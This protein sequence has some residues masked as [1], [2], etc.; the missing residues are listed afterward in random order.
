[1][2][3]KYGDEQSMEILA[4]RIDEILIR[5]A[6]VLL[7]YA[8]ATYELNDQISD[9]DLDISINTLRNRFANDPDK[10]PALTNTFVKEHGLDMREEI[11]RER[12]VELVSESLRYD[13]LI[14]WKTAETELPQEI[15]GAKF[16]K[17]AYPNMVPGKDI[18]L[19]ANGFIIVQ[20]GS[21]RMF[22]PGKDYLFPLPLREISL[23]PNL[24]Q[25]PNW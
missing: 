12:R 15:L 14:R 18:N 21:S 17:S 2:F 3:K 11:R 25:N 13:D 22:D 4:S 20:S 7:T 1:M 10:L 8:E 6:E 24:E 9:A 5:Y 19:N 16:D 23:N